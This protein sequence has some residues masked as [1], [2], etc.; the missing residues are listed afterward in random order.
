MKII[1]RKDIKTIKDNCG[2]L[3]ELYNSDNL[4]MSYSVIT[5]N[6]KP[7]KNK[8]MEEV[9][10]IVKGK[11]KLKVEEDIFPI[12]AGDIFSIPKNK[13]HNIQDIEETI[14]LVV[15]T[16]PKFNPNDLIY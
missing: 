12:E 11:A 4:S 15:I 8:I 7:H 14:E 16:N 1:N 5:E 10:F 13:Y 6:S 3:Q 9:Y 2:K